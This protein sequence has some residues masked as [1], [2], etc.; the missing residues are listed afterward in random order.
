[1]SL[2]APNWL[3][4]PVSVHTKQGEN[5]PTLLLYNGYDTPLD[6]GTTKLCEPNHHIS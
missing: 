4:I 1:M 6:P 2:H 3:I 5:G